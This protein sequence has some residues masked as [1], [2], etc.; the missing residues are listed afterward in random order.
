LGGF[1]RLGRRFGR[2]LLGGLGSRLLSG[3]GRLGRSSGGLGRSFGR[4]LLGGLGGLLLLLLLSG[5]D[6]LGCSSGRLLLHGSLLLLL[7]LLSSWLL[8]HR[9]LLLLLRW[10]SSGLLLH[11]SLRLLLSCWRLLLHNS[12]RG[13]LLHRWALLRGRCRA[14]LY[15]SASATAH[16]WSTVRSTVRCLDVLQ[17]VLQ[18][19]HLS[20]QVSDVPEIVVVERQELLCRIDLALS[21]NH[22]DAVFTP[23][24]HACNLARLLEFPNV[25]SILANDPANLIWFDRQRLLDELQEL[26]CG[27]GGFDRLGTNL[28]PAVAL[29]VDTM[30]S[31]QRLRLGDVLTT[32]TDCET[33]EVLLERKFEEDA[34][35]LLVFHLVDSR[36]QLLPLL[37]QHGDLLDTPKMQS[38]DHPRSVQGSFGA[39]ADEFTT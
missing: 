7:R 13:L 19:L 31:G 34:G 38:D 39:K 30:Y 1:G 3:L 15:S 10:L 21:T 37:L 8:L 14:T 11:R 23:Q 9:S 35:V 25:C 32:L 17:L 36:S 33:N 16:G 18:F 24:R 20:L 6:R 22:H 5:L 4:L 29:N 26:P 2:L 12:S 27:V 28:N